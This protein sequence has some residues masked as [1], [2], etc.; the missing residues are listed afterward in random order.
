MGTKPATPGFMF[1][2]TAVF[3][4]ASFHADGQS[5][6]SFNSLFVYGHGYAFQVREPEGWRGDIKRIAAQHA[7]DAIFLP[8]SGIHS[9]DVS[10]R[11]KVTRKIDDNSIED[12]SHDLQF[13]ASHYPG[14]P[15]KNLALS[16]AEYKTFASSISVPRRLYAYDAFVNPGHGIHFIF[17]V[18]M[19]KKSEPLTDDEIRAFG[20]V[21]TSLQW[22]YTPKK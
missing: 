7:V 5:T 21:V 6:E 13:Y 18:T 17:F 1:V 11:V 14:A 22:L 19:T 15:V 12:M 20:D 8:F 4:A 2:L 9:G 10:I 3:L 16:H